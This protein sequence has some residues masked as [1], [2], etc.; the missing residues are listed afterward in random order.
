MGLSSNILWHQTNKESFCEILMSK[1][2]R[3]SYSL[4]QI[5]PAFYL[6]PIAF[7]MISVSDYPL[8]EIINNQWAYGDFC[9]GFSQKWGIKVGFSPVWY[10]SNGSQSWLQ[11]NTLL[12]DA[13][14]TN[15]TDRFGAIM[16]IFAHMKFVQGT[17][18]TKSRSFEKYRFFDEREWRVVPHIKETDQAEVLPFLD[19]AGYNEFKNKNNNSS[20]LDIGVKFEYD[21]IHYIIV[22]DN[23]DVLDA[24]RIVGDRIHIFTKEEVI[25]D[26][27][28]I[29]H[30]N[31]V[32]PSQEQLE[33]EAA[34]RYAERLVK[35][36]H[37]IFER[38]KN[39]SKL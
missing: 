9:I 6:R 20:L 11:L 2:L 31:E 4:E 30:H 27:A 3:Y 13:L 19:E 23:A 22:K 21:D 17:L 25:E 37:E 14:K 1:K 5:I 16:F 12:D 26:F 36:A 15:S 8:S 38:R 35:K 28:G 18:T 32:L 33:R 24:K 34:Q 7:P 39:E 10:F 29:D